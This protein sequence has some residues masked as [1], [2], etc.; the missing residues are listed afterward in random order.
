MSFGSRLRQSSGKQLFLGLFLC[1]SVGLGFGGTVRQVGSGQTYTT[2]QSC[3]NAAVSGDSCNVHAGTYNENPAFATSGVTLQ[4]NPGDSPVVN[5]FIEIGSNADSV[6]DGFAI[7]SFTHS[8]SGA[9]HAY[10]TTGG[11]IRNNIV[12]GG[13]GAGIYTRLCK[14]FQVYGNTVHDLQGTSGSDGDGMFII[15]SDSLDGTYAH[16]VQVYNNTVYQN[17]QDAIGLNGNWIS[18]YGNLVH[19]NVYS[20]WASVHPDG[21]ECNGVA[22]GFTGCIH[23]LVY[24]NTVYDQ[25][26]NVYFSGNGTASQNGDLW[27][28]NN[29]LFNNPTSSTGVDLTSTVDSSN[30]NISTGTTVHI[31]N[32]TI[33]RTAT[34]FLG[35]FVQSYSDAHIENNIIDNDVGVGIRVDHTPDIAEMDYNLYNTSTGPGSGL[36]QWGGT[37]L[38]SLS[39][40]RSATG[41]ESHGIQA[42]P[43]I[44]PF[45][46]PTIQSSSP[47]IGAALNLTSL[48][49]SQLDTDIVGTA[50]PNSGSW[51]IGA[52]AAASGSLPPPTNLAAIVK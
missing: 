48:G 17:H 50:R 41:D 36:V 7:P 34:N 1:G 13:S 40:V 12:S 31:L 6:V 33:G 5:G 28:F 21:I 22:D 47:V 14:N 27:I 32:N 46:T 8:G 38:T 18:V 15:S 37:F 24:N 10:N 26:Q 49:I 44:N 39:A 45:P 52:Y 30:I 20:N 11:I 25:G 3:L 2:I 4:A 16:G 42:N 19:D 43:Q 29:V 35:I 51:D 23:T 9:I